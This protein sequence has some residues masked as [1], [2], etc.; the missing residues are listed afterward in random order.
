MKTTT[1]VLLGA[2]AASAAVEIVFATP[3][4]NLA[5]GVV[6]AGNSS[7]SLSAHGVAKQTNGDYFNAYLRPTDRRPLPRLW[8]AIPREA[9][10]A[11]I[12]IPVSSSIR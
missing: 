6:G 9:K 5:A 8:R 7:V 12:L 4:I 2:V 10:T 1:K 3:I 11:G